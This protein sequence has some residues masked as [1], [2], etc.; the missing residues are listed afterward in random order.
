MLDFN[1]PKNYNELLPKLNRSTFLTTFLFFI[2][3]R[4]FNIVP[5]VGIANN[6]IPPL[7]DY[8]ELIQWLLSFGVIPLV[9][10][11]IA[12]FLSN[13]FEIHNK[14]AKLLR[15]RYLWDKYFIVKPLTIRA[16][17]EPK[18]TPSRVKQIMNELYYPQ[19]K[20]ID[21]HY[22]ELF[23]RY[24]LP[25][26]VI[27]EHAIIVF[28]TAVILTLTNFGN[29]R[30]WLLWAYLLCVAS[31]AA[32]QLVFVTAQK[33]TDQANQ[34]SEAAVSDFFQNKFK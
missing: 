8:K 2:L 13:A 30:V 5:F 28:V 24:A 33:S 29:A 17:T 31:I 12:L 15:I 19:V 34:I 16:K 4:L 25:F 18:L 26:W 23:W 10:A 27:F 22:V 14:V 3:L 21:Q 1:S 20:K 7:K 32:L 9:A 6:L 11:F